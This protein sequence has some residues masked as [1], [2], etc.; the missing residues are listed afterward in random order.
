[1][2]GFSAHELSVLEDTDFLQTKLIVTKK[3]QQLLNEARLELKSAITKSDF[4]FPGN[5]K[6]LT[7]FFVQKYPD[8]IGFE[9]LTA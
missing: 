2:V 3:L 9:K 7:H 4:S 5:T 1:M 6:G 8:L